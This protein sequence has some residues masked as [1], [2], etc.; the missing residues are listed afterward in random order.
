MSKNLDKSF[1]FANLKY[2][3]LQVY[4]EGVRNENRHLGTSD[5]SLGFKKRL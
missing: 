1:W 3:T 5:K 4:M 2:G